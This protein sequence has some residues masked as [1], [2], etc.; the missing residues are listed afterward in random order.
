MPGPT[1]PTGPP[2]LPGPEGPTGATG[3]PG[4]PGIPG[5]TGPTGIAGP[6]GATGN[7]GPANPNNPAPLAF[8][9]YAPAT[10]VLYTLT[11]SILSIDTV[12]LGLNFTT[13]PTGAVILEANLYLVTS[14]SDQMGATLGYL[15]A[16]DQQKVGSFAL[17][18]H[19]Q[20]TPPGDPE[21]PF[22][23]GSRI[24]YRS[25]VQL[26]PATVY[27]VY[28][29]GGTI[30]TTGIATIVTDNGSECGSIDLFAWEIPL[31]S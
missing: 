1:G 19:Q 15:N 10:Q 6:T 8:N 29:A 23:T 20:Q 28:L 22:V 2:G 25:I 16:P 31:R 5:P 4:T 30:G 7:T 24:C 21:A 14:T 18:E 13:G 12:N 3:A 9:H 17:F 11:P 26:T 27:G